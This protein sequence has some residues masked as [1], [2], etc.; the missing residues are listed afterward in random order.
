VTVKRIEETP[1]VVL[2]TLLPVLLALAL[3]LAPASGPRG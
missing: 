2:L 1:A 3:R